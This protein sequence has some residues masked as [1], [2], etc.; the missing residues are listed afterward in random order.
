[1][2]DGTPQRTYQILLYG[3]LALVPVRIIFVGPP[4]A[5]KGTQGARVAAEFQV[6]HLSTGE[7][8]RRRRDQDDDD[9]LVAS[10]IDGGNLAPDEMVMEMVAERLSKPDCQAGWLMDGFPRTLVQAKLFD[11]YLNHH[12]DRITQ[13]IELV[14]DPE[15]IVDRLLGRA[16]TEDRVDDTPET[17]AHRLKV[18][19]ARTQP[20]LS[21]YRDKDLVTRIDANQDPDTVFTAIRRCIGSQVV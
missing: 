9:G 17:I 3:Q 5:G 1:M 10:Y 15:V 4:G 21:Y 13:V 2:D 6:A 14:V 7:M 12:A 20:V 8:L 19:R 11:G 18:Y 16:K